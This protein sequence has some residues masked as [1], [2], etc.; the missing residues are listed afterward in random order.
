MP[1]VSKRSDIGF[2][3]GTFSLQH[4]LK[5]LLQHPL[6]LAARASAIPRRH[7]NQDNRFHLHGSQRPKSYQTSEGKPSLT[8]PAITKLPMLLAWR[9]HYSTL[10]PFGSTSGFCTW[11]KEGLAKHQRTEFQSFCPQAGYQSWS[12]NSWC[13][14]GQETALWYLG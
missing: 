7:K 8:P 4:P 2:R 12:D 9:P 10:G 1:A 3:C 6:Y 14:W 13:Y 5:P 11:T